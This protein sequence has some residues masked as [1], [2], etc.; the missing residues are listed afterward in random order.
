MI[1]SIFYR[2]FYDVTHPPTQSP[3]M[4]AFVSTLLVHE[5]DLHLRQL[6]GRLLLGVRRW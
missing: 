5:F 2:S 4:H 1:H 3:Q 6:I